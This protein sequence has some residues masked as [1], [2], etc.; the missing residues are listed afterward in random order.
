H[1]NFKLEKSPFFTAGQPHWIKSFYTPELSTFVK[2]SEID[3]TASFYQSQVYYCFFLDYR[4]RG[5]DSTRYCKLVF[6]AVLDLA[7]Q[8]RR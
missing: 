5:N 3:S 1:T 7:N 2:N 4:L 6:L 8:A